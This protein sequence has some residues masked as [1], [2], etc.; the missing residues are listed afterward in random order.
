MLEMWLNMAQ[1]AI[2]L[3]VLLCGLGVTLCALGLADLHAARTLRARPTARMYGTAFVAYAEG[4]RFCEREIFGD[5]GDKASADRITAGWLTSK[6]RAKFD[7]TVQE[8]NT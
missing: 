7:E 1:V 3:G 2:A 6:S 5:D 4:Y 8:T